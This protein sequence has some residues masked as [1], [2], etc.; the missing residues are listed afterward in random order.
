LTLKL[1]KKKY[2]CVSNPAW[3]YIFLAAHIAIS[4][5][6]NKINQH[7]QPATPKNSESVK[8]IISDN[9]EPPKVIRITAGNRPKVVIAGK[10]SIKIDST[11]GGDLFFT[12][13]N[14]EQGLPISMIYCGFADN[15]GNLWFGTAGGG[16]SRYDGKSFTNFTVSQGL[17]S[18]VVTRILP[19]KDGNIWFLTDHGLSQY[20]GKRFLNDNKTNEL[21]S[22]SVWCTLEDRSGNL[23]FGTYTHGVIKYDGKS[24]T[25][26]TVAQ[27]LAGDEV[28]SI[29]QDKSGNYWFGTS[30]HG[31]TKF[32]GK[33]FINYTAA[34]GLA[35][36]HIRG[37]AQ[38]RAGNLW[39][40][41]EAG[42]SRYDGRSFMNFTKAEGLA[43]SNTSKI[44]QDKTGNIWIVF[45]DGGVS[46]YDGQKFTNFTGP[47]G[48]VGKN[49]QSILED[50]SGN[51]WF[52][53]EAGLSRY[54]GNNFTHYTTT[55]GLP[56]DDI[57]GITQDK[58]GNLWFSTM[59]GGVSKF[60]GSSFTDY[61][62]PIGLNGTLIFCIMRDKSGN[63]W[64]GTN[65]RGAV[66][67]DGKSF[68]NYTMAQGLANDYVYGITQDH[69]GDIWFATY[70]GV[71][72]YNGKKFAN[73]LTF[74]GQ[75]IVNGYCLTVDKS[76]NVWIGTR[77][78]GVS[79][80][81]SNSYTHFSMEQGLVDN[82]IYS[83]MQDSHRN[84]WFGSDKGASKYD[85]S[86]FTN[87]T[88]GSGLPDNSISAIIKDKNGNIWFGT[89][90]GGSKYD[91]NRFTNFTT[92]LW[93]GE[94]SINAMAEDS[95]NDIIWCGTNQGLSGVKENIDSNSKSDL[96]EFDDFNYGTGYPIA[97]INQNALSLDS[98]GKIWAGCGDGK[99]LRFDYA[100]VN[101]NLE[102]LTLR[103][104]SIKVN[105]AE[106]CWTNLLPR[107]Q[108][109]RA[110]D[111]LAL[112]N[113]MVTTFG[114]VL[115]PVALDSMLNEYGDIKFDSIAKFNPIP[116]NLVLPYN[117]DNLIF[118]FYAIEPA[119]PKLVKYE[120]KL[121]GYDKA[122]S[123]N[124]NITNAS[125][126]HIREGDYTFKLKALSPYGI[127]SETEYNFK[128]LPPWYRTW[129]AYAFYGICLL[130]GIY[131]TDR[132]R[133]KVVIERERAKA[134]E[135]ELAQAKEIEKAYTELKA[136]QVQLVQSEK[137]ASLGELTAGIAHEIQNPLNFVN[138]FSEVNRELIDEASQAI[139][140]GNPI[141]VK[142]LL[143]TL[144][145]NEE[146]IN[147]HGKRADAIVKG[148]LQH[149][150]SGTGQKELAN[151]NGVAD[152]CLRLSYHA[153]RA[154]DK[155]FNANLQTDFDDTIDKIPLIQQDIVRVFVNLYNN[156]FYAVSE[157]K[158]FTNAGYEP[159]VS[160][161]TKKTNNKITITVKDNGN[162]IPQKVVDK[163]FQ[164]FF[165]TKPTGQGTGLG[166]SLS[167]DIVKAHGGE[168]KVNT[169]EN[170]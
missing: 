25:K 17:A 81:D 150:R 163:I 69:H 91:G 104:N 41:T 95:I 118:D 138:N 97:E 155:S 10:P 133:R 87:Y 37:I 54:D 116:I 96:F 75:K 111:S 135:K 127:W 74:E 117:D 9:F 49:L 5:C 136:T 55:Q 148:M 153:I 149:S 45:R 85:G 157:K 141:E 92:G 162:G 154:K 103:L 115:P 22:D 122:W 165:T 27:G 36:N 44:V 21:V 147:H 170:E 152:E 51:L 30:R 19:G 102:P 60:G 14:K 2:L 128:I 101:R 132:I 50:K 169:K 67:Y 88:T 160:V 47:R 34:Q 113:E 106:I 72:K 83:I 100:A 32:D 167:Y 166:L 62:K 90:K 139:A 66:K 107:R 143:S 35:G 108:R 7:T 59:G 142:E 1:P 114:Q 8:G 13:Y 80:L 79:K 58:A 40:A 89:D 112:L 129:W 145:D 168:I 57:R 151:I 46:K 26:Y 159:E 82:S 16:A 164:P 156:A 105:N 11:N 39:F 121:E 12:N 6:N 119:K 43:D 76:G 77:G 70:E 48:P 31:V 161:S 73:Y 64:F 123:P 68:T 140:A 71:S 56:G 63:L 24:F 61:T 158:K 120:Y 38:D 98:K 3:H 52:A 29:I 99:L 86:R 134:R 124:T 23:W 131:L 20:D 18:N 65:G 125:F 42:I 137:M 94:K 4:S 146:K 126:A 28:F 15:D 78:G 109:F 130:A 144:K 53:S 93:L 84:I 33:N 110:A